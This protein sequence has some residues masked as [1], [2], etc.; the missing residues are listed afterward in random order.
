MNGRVS[1]AAAALS[2]MSSSMASFCVAAACLAPLPAMAGH[3]PTAS[4]ATVGEQTTVPFGWVDFCRRYDGECSGGPLPPLDIVTTS[5]TIKEIE[6]INKWVNGHVEAVSDKDH[7]GVIDEWDYPTDGK[8]D[9]EDYALLKRK[10]LIE[11]GFPRQAL[12]MTVVKDTKKE[13]HAILTVKTSTGEFVLDNLVNDVKP[14][15]QT[16]YRFVKRQSQADQNVWVQ[17]GD[18]TPA[19]DYVSGR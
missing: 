4:F 7:W 18:P 19:P 12:L 9:C 13:G 8:G 15:D 6:R 14:W 2:K 5:K 16:G 11:E 1:R 3:L 10:I 17:L